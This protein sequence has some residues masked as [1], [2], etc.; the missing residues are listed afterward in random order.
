MCGYLFVGLEF[1]CVGVFDYVKIYM[2]YLS[3]EFYVDVVDVFKVCGFKG[4]VDEFEVFVVVVEKDK[5]VDVVEVVYV[6]FMNVIGDL[7]FK[8]VDVIKFSVE[9]NLK[10]VVNFICMVGDEYVIGVVD[11]KLVNVYEYQ[12]VYGFIE[13]VKGIV[14]DL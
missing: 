12:D 6:M 14:G 2:K 11:G 4:F 13:V 10:V 1:F 9:E 3:V 7:E 5:E 8:V